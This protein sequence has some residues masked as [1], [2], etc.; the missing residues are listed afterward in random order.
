MRKMAQENILFCIV[1]QKF[2]KS[3]R[4]ISRFGVKIPEIISLYDWN[5]MV[6][7]IMKLP[8]PFWINL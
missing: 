7:L 2:R 3:I 4:T 5:R 1:M 8:M 6:K